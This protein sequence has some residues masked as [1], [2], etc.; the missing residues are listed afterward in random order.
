MVFVIVPWEKKNYVW[1]LSRSCHFYSWTC[2]NN[3]SAYMK[4]NGKRSRHERSNREKLVHDICNLLSNFKRVFHKKEDNLF[5]VYFL[6]KRIFSFVSTI[7]LPNGDFFKV[8]CFR[9]HEMDSFFF[10]LC[11]YNVWVISLPSPQPL[12]YPTPHPINT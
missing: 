8:L 12:P 9:I 10:F 1:F 7:H 5:C 2:F 6:R 3:F 11:A 4:M